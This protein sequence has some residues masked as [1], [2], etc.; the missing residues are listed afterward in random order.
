M[1][2]T[3]RIH[4]RSGHGSGLCIEPGGSNLQDVE[5]VSLFR[6]QVCVYSRFYCRCTAEFTGTKVAPNSCCTGTLLTSNSVLYTSHL[7]IPYLLMTS[8]PN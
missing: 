6:T 5:Y 7:F 4:W 2:L 1:H 3:C 8:Y